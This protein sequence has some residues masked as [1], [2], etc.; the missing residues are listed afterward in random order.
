MKVYLPPYPPSHGDLGHD[1]ALSEVG[2]TLWS[3]LVLDFLV[4][5]MPIYI[6]LYIGT[7]FSP[8]SDRFWLDF[9][10]F[11]APVLLQNRGQIDVVVSLV[12]G[13]DFS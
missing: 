10:P 8:I 2:V 6:S 4:I 3:A 13:Y 12:F 5:L 11:L 7:H 1:F 9:R